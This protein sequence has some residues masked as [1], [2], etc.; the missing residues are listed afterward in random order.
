MSV[1]RSFLSVPCRESVKSLFKHQLKRLSSTSSNIIESGLPDVEI[2]S[3]LSIPQ[4][5]FPK[6]EKYEH[7]TAIVSLKSS[8]L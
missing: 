4:H 3:N 5:I 1:F 6:F 2:P 8:H 7:L